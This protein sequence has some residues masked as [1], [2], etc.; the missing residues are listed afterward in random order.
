MLAKG[1]GK[2]GVKLGAGP[3]LGQPHRRTGPA[4][5]M[6]HLGELT[7]SSQPRGDGD[8]VALELA[9]PALPVPLLVGTTHRLLHP[10][11]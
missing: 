11:R 10:R 7:D 1:R 5:P 6:G 3:L 9:G 4:D 8:A 2:R